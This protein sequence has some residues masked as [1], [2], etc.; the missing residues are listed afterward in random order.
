MTPEPMTGPEQFAF[1]SLVDLAAR[2]DHQA[3]RAAEH[4]D[5]DASSYL[6]SLADALRV[7]AQQV[8][9]T[10]LDE[11]ITST[12][13]ASR[14]TIIANRDRFDSIALARNLDSPEQHTTLGGEH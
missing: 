7:N 2:A 3:A 12:I 9:A 4:N 11:R 8:K 10:G 1:D 6:F 5:L 14:G 13:D